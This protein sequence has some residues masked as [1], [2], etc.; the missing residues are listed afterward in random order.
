MNNAEYKL[1]TFD[2][3]VPH[4]ISWIEE[5]NGKVLI[6]QKKIAEKITQ[7]DTIAADLL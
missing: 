3:V 2:F 4:H 1:D 7:D 6:T 5:T